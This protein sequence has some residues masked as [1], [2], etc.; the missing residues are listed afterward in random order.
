MLPLEAEYISGFYSYLC[1]VK[2]RKRSY[3]LDVVHSKLV[4]WVG[5]WN[6]GY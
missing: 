1:V 5:Q 6:W 4:F 2:V 3:T